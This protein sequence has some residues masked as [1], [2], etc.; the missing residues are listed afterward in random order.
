MAI[1]IGNMMINH[2]TFRYSIFRHFRIAKGAC[3]S[4]SHLQSC[5]PPRHIAWPWNRAVDRAIR[6][7]TGNPQ[8]WHTMAVDDE[9]LE[10]LTTRSKIP[11]PQTSQTS[12]SLQNNKESHLPIFPTNHPFPAPPTSAHISSSEVTSIRNFPEISATV[13]QRG[14]CFILG[15]PEWWKSTR[16]L[17]SGLITMAWTCASVLTVC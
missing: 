15:W 12:N 5:R 10:V 4:Q 6:G 17:T 13:T 1:L 8:I 9:V 14:S 7:N 3:A 16:Q 11:R 2:Q